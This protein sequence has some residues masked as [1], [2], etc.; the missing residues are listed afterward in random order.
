MLK[1]THRG[2]VTVVRDVSSELSVVASAV[3]INLRFV[4]AHVGKI[5][6]AFTI[7]DCSLDET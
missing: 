4:R 2:I 5:G 3:I 6:S 7:V 1:P